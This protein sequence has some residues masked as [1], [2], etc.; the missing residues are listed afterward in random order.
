MVGGADIRRTVA[1]RLAAGLGA[2]FTL[3][4]LAMIAV[5]FALVEQQLT[6]RTDQVLI[7]ELDRLT[8][9][10]APALPAQIGALIANSASGLNYYALTARD[11]RLIAGNFTPPPRASAS[12][13]A[14]EVPAGAIV[15]A[16]LRLMSLDRPDGTRIAVA[17][18]I[19][20]IAAMRGAVLH[21]TLGS[22][23]VVIVIALMTGA[24]LA[25]GPLAR[26]GEVQAIAARIAAG[27]LAL[28]I[29]VTRTG[30]ELDLIAG[31]VNTM[32]DEIERL[33]VEVKGTTDAIA[34]DL[35]A[36]MAHL[37]H[38]L[39]QLLPAENQPADGPVA[40]AVSDALGDVDQMLRRFNALLRISELEAAN[41]RAG[42]APLDPMTLLADIAE[43]FEPLAE[44]NDIRLLIQ[45]SFGHA[46]V[47]DQALL[48]EAISNLVENALKFTGP[49]GTVCLSA[50]Q[51]DRAT[52]IEVRDNGPG[53][54]AEDRVAVMGR[55]RRG[56]GAARA[57]G[58]GLGLSLVAAIINLH[59]FALTL[60][61]AAPGLVVAIS[62]PRRALDRIR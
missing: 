60:E 6:A 32:L 30:D 7:H 12:P 56:A 47:G 52:V 31:M 50:M 53:I 44:A 17:R 5:I 34:H 41:R 49:G 58:H 22:A 45:G 21:V 2:V 13:A 9:L 25:R 3:A 35:R 46:I 15:A 38:R 33:L 37:R 19:T 11:G 1:F 54:A 42:F 27:E 16:P 20:Q 57:A 40:A 23:A 51:T 26:V 61:D 36:P 48:I 39:A 43:L 29:P 55:L 62:I 4:A 14:Y 10:P 18:D 8:A 28:R 59:G 24:I